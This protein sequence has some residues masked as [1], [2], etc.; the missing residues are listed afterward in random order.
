MSR[1]D[2][3]TVERIIA[4]TIIET[5]RDDPDAL[6]ARIVAALAGAGY[7]IVPANGMEDAPRGSRPDYYGME[8]LYRSPNGDS[9]FLA[10]DPATGFGSVRHQ[11]NA[12]S[13]GRVT[14]LEI[15]A[16]LS[17]PANP[18]Q[19]AL[20][21]VIGASIVDP[22]G[23]PVEDEPPG[24]DTETEWSDAD[25]TELGNMLVRSLSIEE[26]ARVLGR[27]RGEV[28][29]KVVE[30]GRACRRS[31]ATESEG[32]VLAGQDETRPRPNR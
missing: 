14:D 31:A 26:I 13:G 23:T 17:G 1:A 11:A 29:D 3:P 27:D 15:G 18:E 22:Q 5:A 6:A 30:I 20:L 21:R 12:S 4:S 10:R 28:Q 8:Q 2:V 25:L 32:R 16:F 19:K 24:T 7:R 9:W